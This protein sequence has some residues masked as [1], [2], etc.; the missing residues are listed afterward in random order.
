MCQKY[1]IFKD[2]FNKICRKAVVWKL[3]NTVEGTFKNL[4]K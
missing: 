1:K 4:N 2:R 3:F